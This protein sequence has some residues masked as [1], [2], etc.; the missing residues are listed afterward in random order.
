MRR[1]DPDAADADRTRT[2]DPDRIIVAPDG[3]ANDKIS[4]TELDGYAL[5]IDDVRHHRRNGAIARAFEIDC[6]E[7][8]QHVDGAPHAV[9]NVYAIRRGDLEI[10]PVP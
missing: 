4:G 2:K 8:H 6:A 9:G 3:F 10:S 5:G 1:Q 7:L